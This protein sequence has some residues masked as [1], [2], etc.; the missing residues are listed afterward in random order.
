MGDR[1]VRIIRALYVGG[2]FTLLALALTFLIPL[3]VA[4]GAIFCRSIISVALGAFAEQPWFIVLFVVVCIALWI[5][6]P[7]TDQTS[8]RVRKG[9][10]LQKREPK[11]A[12]PKKTPSKK[13]YTPNR[14]I[15]PKRWS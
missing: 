6:I 7:R 9:R 4:F 3:M 13:P 2:V 14:P 11:K 15:R 12:L 5:W 8:E 10:R 1:L